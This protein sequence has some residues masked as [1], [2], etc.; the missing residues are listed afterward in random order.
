M[1]RHDDNRFE[2]KPRPPRAR[3]G[4]RSQ[5][6][7]SRVL[8]EVRRAG[9]ATQSGS[10]AKRP[11]SRIGRGFAAS[12]LQGNAPGPRARHVVIK[13]RVVVL[14]TAG[15]AAISAHLRYIARDGVTRD[16]EPANP[17]SAHADRVDLRDF[18]TRGAHDRHQFRFIVAP[19]DATELADLRGFTRHLMAR[20][21]AD[22]GTR[23]DWVAVDHWDTDNPHTHIVLRGKDAAGGD[24]VI[25]GD[26]IARGMRLRAGELATEWLGPRTDLEIQTRLQREVEQERWTSLDRE[27]KARSKDGVVDLR[28]VG[29]TPAELGHRARLLGRLQHLRALGVAREDRPA[30]WTLRPDAEDVLRALGERGDIIRTMQRAFGKEPRELSVFDPANA[31]QPIVGRI[32]A[33]GLVDELGDQGYVVVDGLDGRGH[34]VALPVR[35]SLDDLPL[36]GIVSVRATGE[37]AADRNILNASRNGMYQPAEHRAA[38]EVAG[39]HAD[40][41]EIVAS[42]VRRLEAL[43]RAGVVQRLGDG[44]WRVPKDL[45]ARGQRVR[46]PASGRCYRTAAIALVDRKASAGRWRDLARPATR[47]S[48]EAGGGDWLCWIGPRC[49]QSTRRFSG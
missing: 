9:G 38:L 7:L 25:A 21:E 34:Y 28:E 45:V 44:L 42:H 43:R 26:Y 17:Y 32:A 22:L 6:F 35:F 15:A 18:Q 40:A 12:R 11:G 24:L 39:H 8:V 2:I 49:A 36:G 27:L 20:M 10:A 16:G 29:L 30:E 23:L 33:K 46:P 47:R 5:R 19:E 41:D 3:P 14:Q 48:V 1:T 37:R 4:P 13:T 31:A